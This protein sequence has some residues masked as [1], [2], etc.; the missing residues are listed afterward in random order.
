MLRLPTRSAP[1]AL[2]APRFAPALFVPGDAPARFAPALPLRL[3][4]VAGCVRADAPD[5]GGP[6]PVA[7]PPNR[8]APCRRTGSRCCDRVRR[9]PAM[10]WIVIPVAAVPVA[11]VVAVVVIHIPVVHVDVDAAVAPSRAVAPAAAAPERAHRDAHAEPDRDTC[12]VV[13]DGRVVDRRIGI[14]RRAVD[15]DGVIGRDVNH[16]R[17][18]L[19][20][21]DDFLVCTT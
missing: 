1:P 5:S 6:P 21:D 7:S 8:P 19:L 10:R 4:P 11:T 13:A 14:N 18:G 12:R 3:A 17:I 15:D 16:L 9:T 2:A 20:D